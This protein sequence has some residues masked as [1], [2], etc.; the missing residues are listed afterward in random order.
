MTAQVA[1]RLIFADKEIPLFTNPLSPYLKQM[2][3][4]FVSNSTANWRGYVATWEMIK[5]E[6]AERLYLVKLRA[7]RTRSELIGLADLF[8]GFDKVFAHW[9]SGE[10]RCP[11][12]ERLNYVH[13]GYSS[14][15]EYDLMMELKQGVLVHKYAKHNLSPERSPSNIPLDFLK[16]NDD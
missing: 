6:G 11:Q 1:D 2:G 13:G 4:Q 12:G 16:G 9:F 15:Y 10:L 14:T 7:N 3:I 8:P 5:S